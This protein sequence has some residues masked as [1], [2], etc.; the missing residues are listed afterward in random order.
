MLHTLRENLMAIY[1]IP[2]AINPVRSRN[3]NQSKIELNWKDRRKMAVY[4]QRMLPVIGPAAVDATSTIET[5]QTV[6]GHQNL[7]RVS[8]VAAKWT[9]MK[10]IDEEAEVVV[11]EVVVAETQGVRVLGPIRVHINSTPIRTVTNTT[12][13]K[14][15]KRYILVKY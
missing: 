14:K 5:D 12:K 3:T 2:T 4:L 9:T 6:L 1:E 15:Y 13:K 10:S 11:V 7:V 8:T